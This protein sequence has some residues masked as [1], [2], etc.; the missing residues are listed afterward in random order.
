MV[1]HKIL[2]NWIYWFVID[3]ISIP[4]YIDRGLYLTAILFVMY[5]VIVVFGYFAWIREYRGNSVELSG[6]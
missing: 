1:A 5:L 2:E 3:A 4:L 6:T